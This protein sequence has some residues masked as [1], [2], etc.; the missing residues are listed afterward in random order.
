MIE[1][2]ILE[3]VYDETELLKNIKELV[4]LGCQ[5]GFTDFLKNLSLTEHEAKLET[6]KAKYKDEQV[7][8]IK[9]SFLGALKNENIDKVQTLMELIKNFSKFEY[10]YNAELDFTKKQVI[11]T[12]LY[13]FFAKIKS[14]KLNVMLN[15]VLFFFCYGSEEWT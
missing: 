5:I 6:L 12:N 4:S 15:F 1:K 7:L 11:R 8:T 3:G 10:R 14:T 9:N 13:Y 2:S